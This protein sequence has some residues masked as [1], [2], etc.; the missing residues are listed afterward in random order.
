MVV[1]EERQIFASLRGAKH[2]PE[3]LEDF[4]IRSGVQRPLTMS[5]ECLIPC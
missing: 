1:G 5:M 2:I 4:P 3:L